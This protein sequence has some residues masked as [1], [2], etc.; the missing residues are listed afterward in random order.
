MDGKVI[1]ISNMIGNGGA[2]RVMNLLANYLVTCKYDV[3]IC[4]YSGFDEAYKMSNEIKKVSIETKCKNQVIQKIQRIFYLRKI[5]KGNPETPI[6]AFEYFIN[7]QTILASLFLKNKVIISERNNP[8]ELDSRMHMK[9]FRDI[10]YRF[11]DVL[12]CQTPDA[13]NYFSSHIKKKSIVIPNPL[14]EKLPE[15]YTGIRKKVIVN[16]CRLEPQKNLKMLLDAC[17]LLFKEYEEYSLSIYGNG[18]EKERLLQYLEEKGISDKV[19]IYDF[20][21]NIHEK[22]RNCS[23]YASS[24]DYEG[25]S[26]SM[27]EALGMGLP[28]VVTDCPCGGAKMYITSYENGILVP[29][30]DATAMYKA[31]KYIID[32]PEKSEYMSEN[33]IKIKKMLNAENIYSRWMKLLE[34]S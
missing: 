29:V 16:F 10:L 31:M 13:Q 34:M 26:N 2:G 9:I 24:S 22:I 21:L 23:I 3:T 28:T 20:T 7:M 11:A 12:V 5:F 32:H 17:D 6:I 30:G 27:L 18:S 14:I 4:S 1:F 15:R 19:K 25:I 8:G 33:A